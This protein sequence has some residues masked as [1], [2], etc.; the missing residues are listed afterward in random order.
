MGVEQVVVHRAD[1][2]VFRRAKVTNARERGEHGSLACHRA[3]CRCPSCRGARRRYDREHYALRQL[4][5]TGEINRRISAR[6]TA[7]H[8]DALRARGWSWPKLAAAT[9]FAVPTLQRIRAQPE[10]RCWSIVE[11]AVLAVE[12]R[13]VCGRGSEVV[14]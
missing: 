13:P 14:P 3:G 10:R 8:L 4:V 5:R 6:A 2:T 1:G 9:G 11:Q 12:P 7:E